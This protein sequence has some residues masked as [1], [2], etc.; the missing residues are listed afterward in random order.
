MISWQAMVGW[1][2]ISRSNPLTLSF[3]LILFVCCITYKTRNMAQWYRHTLVTFMTWVRAPGL[4][5]FPYI[6]PLN[7]FVCN[8]NTGCPSC[9]YKIQLSTRPKAFHQW[10]Q[11]E[12]HDA[13][14]QQ[15]ST[16]APKSTRPEGHWAW[17]TKAVPP[18]WGLKPPR[19]AIYFYILS[20]YYFYF[21]FNYCFWLIYYFHKKHKTP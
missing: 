8:F 16:L 15:R 17:I 12:E 18:L 2:E 4:H 3:Y 11:S 14:G 10:P 1:F 7:I 5:S 20:F 13:L 9:T 21:S 6:F 19:F